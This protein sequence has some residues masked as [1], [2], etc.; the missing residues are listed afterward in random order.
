MGQD[1][2]RID[3][4]SFQIGTFSHHRF[5][6]AEELEKSKSKRSQGNVAFHS[7]G[8]RFEQ[9]NELSKLSALPGK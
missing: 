2:A 3:S 4:S 1:E 6:K 7:A 9:F 5:G 8:R